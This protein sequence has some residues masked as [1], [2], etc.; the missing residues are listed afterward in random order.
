MNDREIACIGISF[1]ASIAQKQNSVN[2]GDNSSPKYYWIVSKHLLDDKERIKYVDYTDEE[3]FNVIWKKLTP[4]ERTKIQIALKYHCVSKEITIHKDIKYTSYGL[5]NRFRNL[6]IMG[7]GY[8]V[9]FNTN[10]FEN[11]FKNSE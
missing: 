7:N 5:L 4:A 3:I 9:D 1:Y 8:E 11:P 10:P 2:F 6:T